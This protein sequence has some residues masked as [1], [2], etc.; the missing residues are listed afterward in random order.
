MWCTLFRGGSLQLSQVA[1]Q[2]FS[3]AHSQTAGLVKLPLCA[4][5]CVADFGFCFARFSFF[6]VLVSLLFR[7]LAFLCLFSV[8]VLGFLLVRFCML[9]CL[10]RFSVAFWLAERFAGFCVFLF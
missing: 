8:V 1:T 7:S 9:E 5:A 4:F 10:F 6:G 2:L 3:S